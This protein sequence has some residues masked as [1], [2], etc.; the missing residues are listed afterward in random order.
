MLSS[1]VIPPSAQQV[2]TCFKGG[3][4]PRTSPGD[5][6]STNY[7]NMLA[8]CVANVSCLIATVE[9][10]RSRSI[11]SNNKSANNIISSYNQKI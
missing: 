10:D 1:F 3:L 8:F 11:R 9:S 5:G 7:Y 6:S 2:K 4:S